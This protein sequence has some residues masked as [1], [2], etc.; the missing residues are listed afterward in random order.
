MFAPG[1]GPASGVV[2]RLVKC[3][4]ARET[5]VAG[6]TSTAVNVGCV[7]SDGLHH[8]RLSS[9]CPVSVQPQIPSAVTGSL[10]HWLRWPRTGGEGRGGP[11]RHRRHLQLA[12]LPYR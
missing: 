6:S 2:C 12:R 3:R 5:S 1:G 10:V 7:G 9:V 8:W 4:A 11:A